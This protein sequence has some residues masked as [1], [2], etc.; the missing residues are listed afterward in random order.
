MNDDWAMSFPFEGGTHTRLSF[1]VMSVRRAGFS[2]IGDKREEVER[3]AGRNNALP[4]RKA[5]MEEV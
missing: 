2:V 5:M 1:R 3:R 4:E